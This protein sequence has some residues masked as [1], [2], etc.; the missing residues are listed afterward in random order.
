MVKYVIQNYG[1]LCLMI[2]NG[3]FK[4]MNGDYIRVLIYRCKETFVE[5]CNQSKKQK[6]KN[7]QLQYLK[8]YWYVT[9][10]MTELAKEKIN[11]SEVIRNLSQSQRG[12]QKVLKAFNLCNGEKRRYSAID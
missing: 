10:K 2:K 6:T 7:F 3:F 8:K 12:T 1:S 4:I 9:N 5:W 11:A